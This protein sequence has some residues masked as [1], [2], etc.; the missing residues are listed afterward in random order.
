[1]VCRAIAK[2]SVTILQ[3][4]YLVIEENILSLRSTNLEITLL[5]TIKLGN[6]EGIP[7]Q[8]AVKLLP[9]P[10][11]LSLLSK[12]TED[13]VTFDWE[14]DNSE[15]FSLEFGKHK[16]Q[17]KNLPN[18]NDF[19]ILPDIGKHNMSLNGM[20][21]SRLFNLALPFTSN[22]RSESVFS[23]VFLRFSQGKIMVYSTDRHRLALVGL[24]S[25]QEMPELACVIPRNALKTALAGFEGDRVEIFLNEQFI[26]F[27]GHDWQAIIGLIQERYPDILGI[28]PESHQMKVECDKF[29][30]MMAIKLCSQVSC[31]EP[32][33]DLHF[34]EEL[35]VSN[36]GVF[37]D[38]TQP[39]E[40]SIIEGENLPGKQL[41]IV[42]LNWKYFYELL[43]QVSSNYI[44]LETEGYSKPVKL[45]GKTQPANWDEKYILIPIRRPDIEEKTEAREQESP[46]GSSQKTP[47]MEYVDGAGSPPR[48]SVF[49]PISRWIKSIPEKLHLTASRPVETFDDEQQDVQ[50]VCGECASIGTEDCPRDCDPDHPACRNFQ[51]NP[52]YEQ[53][54]Q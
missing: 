8:R 54:P 22:E 23:G 19:P 37:G 36:Q 3:Y 44:V 52:E 50:Y 43:K 35:F 38:A 24:N 42:R 7:Q 28:M 29:S 1:M 25:N 14:G 20:D 53:V 32:D 2:N 48:E 31:S 46:D 51:M 4:V 40:G 34:G 27:K 16:S 10:F 33:V 15:T 30:L 9:G 17:V 13:N 45:Y 21:L 5:K 47:E 41:D 11:V 49:A 6:I 26:S 18:I 39:F 12:C